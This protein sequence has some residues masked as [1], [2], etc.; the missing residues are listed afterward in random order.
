MGAIL[1]LFSLSRILSP[2]ISVKVKNI[3]SRV[4][5]IVAVI[6]VVLILS[7]RWAPLGI[8]KGIVKNFIFISGLFGSLLLFFFAFHIVYSRVLIWCLKHKFLFMIIPLIIIIT[9]SMTWLGFHSFFGWLPSS[10]KTFP[11]VSYMWHKFP[12]LGKEFMPPLDEGSFL[13]MPTTMPHAS[14]GEALDVLQKQDMAISNIHETESVV[15][16]IGRAETALDPAPVSMIETIINYSD[17]FLKDKNGR[18]LLFKFNPQKNDLFR[19][20]KG[21]PVTAPDGESYFVHGRFTRDRNMQ[22][23]PSKSGM[24]FRLWRSPLDPELNPGRK[25]W[26]GISR[27]V[28]IWNEITR[29]SRIPGTTSAPLLQPIS[30]RIVM[31][32]SGMRAPM[33]IKV[34]GPDLNS[35]EKFGVKLEALLR[36]HP[37]INSST[38]FADRIVGKPYIE[39]VIDRKAIARYEISL[40]DVQD[41]IETSL[42]GKTV[43]VTVEGRERYAVRVRYMRELRDDIDSLKK[44]LV[45]APG[46]AHIPIGQISSLKHVRGPQMIKSEDTFLVGYVLFDKK[47]GFAEV[48][49]VEQVEKYLEEKIQKG[50]LTVPAGVSFTFAGSYENQIRA[51]KKLRII[52]PLSLILI[53]LILYFQFKSVSTTCIV[54]STIAV[55]WAGG[56][57]MIWLYA[58]PWFL[59]FSIFGENLRELFQVHQINLS[60]AVWVGFL[61]LF[62]I[63]SDDGVVM[64]TFVEQIFK[65]EKPGTIQEIRKAVL[66]AGKKRIR[67]CLMT[68]ATT[69]LALIP[70]L[71]S[72][73]RGADIMIPMAIPTFGGIIT[74][75]LGLFMAPVLYSMVKELQ[76][77]IKF[78]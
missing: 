73:G 63:A 19:N 53:F 77:R 31:L 1:I 42:G 57:V 49:V 20:V 14:I 59:N 7:W 10:V 67:P 74:V 24:P 21:D 11:P 55:A 37:A 6:C 22:L 48:D 41:V 72:T 65:R 45:P 76:C 43:T 32:Q 46:G 52:L 78:E 70:V 47:P 34:K 71:T 62:G 54:F 35:I 9:G 68:S 44:I 33:G 3:L 61:A 15:G 25:A 5:N 26:K 69:A 4:F 2:F 36:E 40:Q 12:G 64:A 28:D 27:P 75:S 39:I 18:V 51:Q 38:V 23:I 16:K 56:F 50:Q 8:E 58:Q 29:V 13:F 60:V 30:A 17:K 66:E